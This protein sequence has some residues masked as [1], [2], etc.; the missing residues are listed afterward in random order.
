[1][2]GT[3]SVGN[4][5]QTSTGLA[6]PAGAIRDAT[7]LT[8]QWIVCARTGKWAAAIRTGLDRCVDRPRGQR[9]WET[10][11]LEGCQQGLCRWPASLVAIEVT[12]TRFSTAIDWIAALEHGFPQ[13][14]A[15]VFSQL[16]LPAADW[17][18]REAGAVCI[19]RSLRELEPM[20]R[21]AIRHLQRA[22]TRDPG[23]AKRILAGLPW[24]GHAR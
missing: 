2:V 18:L 11:N 9:V 3:K 17:A 19:A 15:A 24:A 20:I 22:P 21:L 4:D 13:A 23:I 8:A 5:A 14:R 7:T 6:G 10:R 1:M 12:R 16:D